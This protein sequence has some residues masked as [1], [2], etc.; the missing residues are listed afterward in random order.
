MQFK[1]FALALTA[2][3]AVSA[4]NGTANGTKNGTKNGS[5]NNTGSSSD[6]G[7]VQVVG[8]GVFGAVAAAGVALL[9]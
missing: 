8:A 9:I 3:T 5:K 2:A 7:A 4:A 6:S 1:T